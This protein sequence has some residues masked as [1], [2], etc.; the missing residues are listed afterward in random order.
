M[1]AYSTRCSALYVVAL[2]SPTLG[3]QLFSMAI[4]RLCA[5]FRLTLLRLF[6]CHKIFVSISKIQ[7]LAQHDS[8]TCMKYVVRSSFAIP[9]NFLYAITRDLGSLTAYAFRTNPKHELTQL[10]AGLYSVGN[11]LG[12]FCLMKLFFFRNHRASD[13]ALSC[14]ATLFFSLYLVYDT[15]RY[16]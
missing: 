10:G 9:T 11:A 13:L 14:V 5:V 15:Y 7:D 16:A 1:A 12:M 2:G 4:S 8:I 6:V 3:L